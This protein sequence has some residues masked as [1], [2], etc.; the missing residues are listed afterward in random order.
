M[1]GQELTGLAQHILGDRDDASLSAGRIRDQT[2][3][4]PVL[5][6]LEVRANHIYRH[7]QQNKIAALFYELTKTLF[8][9]KASLVN[10]ALIAGHGNRVTGCI[11]TEDLGRGMGL[12]EGRSKRGPDKAQADDSNPFYTFAHR[13]TFYLTDVCALVFLAILAD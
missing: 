6:V 7:R 5:Q 1:T 11:D 2:L 8:L 3:V 9:R 4:A 12:P 13:R 10:P